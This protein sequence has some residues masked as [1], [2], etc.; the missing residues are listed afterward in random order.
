M[1][2]QRRE[3]ELCFRMTTT[4]C[5]TTVTRPAL[6]HISGVALKMTFEVCIICK[7]KSRGAILPSTTLRSP[8]LY[9]TIEIP[10]FSLRSFK[11][12][13]LLVWRAAAVGLS[14]ELS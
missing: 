14:G 5:A 2:L 13:D 7:G 8:R 11:T 4:P 6:N 9:S 10:S 12:T 1:K 3:F